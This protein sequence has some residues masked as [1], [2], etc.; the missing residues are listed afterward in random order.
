MLL[1]LIDLLDVIKM[2]FVLKGF[3]TYIVGN[4]VNKSFLE[5]ANEVFKVDKG[6]VVKPA[7]IFIFC[8]VIGI[9]KFAVILFLLIVLGVN[10]NR[11][12]VVNAVVFGVDIFDVWSD[13]VVDAVVDCVDIVDVWSDNVVDAVVVCVDIVDVWISNVVGAVV[14]CV[15]IFVK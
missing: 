3:V 11:C 4:V 10:S 7:F 8:T 9:V 14:V 15:D 1:F 12:N 2:V 13:D 5:F 6:I